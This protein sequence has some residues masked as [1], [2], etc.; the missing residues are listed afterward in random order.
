[1]AIDAA[2]A[3]AYAQPF[4]TAVNVEAITARN[5]VKRSI[6]VGPIIIAAAWFLSDGLGA[7]AATVGVIVIVLNFLLAG[8][9]LSRAAK[10]SLQMYQVAATFGFFVR[11]GFVTLSMF[12]AAWLFDLDRVPL[13]IAAITAFIALLV[14]ESIAMLRG[15]RKD[16]EWS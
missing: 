12:G 7:F 10:V 9:L 2:S 1:M 5:I 6:V 3:E 13:G 4:P 16:L 11:L 15:A 14:L 8:W